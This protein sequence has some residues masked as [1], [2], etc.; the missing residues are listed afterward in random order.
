[1]AR[2]NVVLQMKIENVLTDIMAQ[3]GADNVIVDSST[4]EMLSTR[5]ASIAT[6]V[7]AAVDMLADGCGVVVPLGDVDAMTTAI[8]YFEDLDTRQRAS[9]CAVKKVREQYA[10][11]VILERFK[12]Y[13]LL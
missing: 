10:T 6:D 3:T 2:K 4:N 13:Y 9:A 7:G 1:M 8:E 12:N 5:L 11:D